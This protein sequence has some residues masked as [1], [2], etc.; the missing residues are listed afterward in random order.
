MNGG[1]DF[2]I[3]ILGLGALAFLAGLGAWIREILNKPD[4]ASPT[5]TRLDPPKPARAYATTTGSTPPEVTT[6]QLTSTFLTD[7]AELPVPH[8]QEESSHQLEE[9]VVDEFKVKAET[10]E[11]NG[12]YTESLHEQVEADELL[13]EAETTGESHAPA[14]EEFELKAE[15]V[16]ADKTYAESLQEQVDADEPPASA[17]APQEP[18]DDLFLT[19][20]GNAIW[21]SPE[22]DKDNSAINR[23]IFRN[24]FNSLIFAFNGFSSHKWPLEISFNRE[25][26]KRYTGTAKYENISVHCTI[27]FQALHGR[28]LEFDGWWQADR[29]DN[30]KY[31]KYRF[32]GIL[33]PRGQIPLPPA[34][35]IVRPLAPRAIPAP[36]SL[37]PRQISIPERRFS[38]GYG[39]FNGNPFIEILENERPWGETHRNAKKHFSFG[40][41]KAKMI[42][43][44]EKQ[45][46]EFVASDGEGTSSSSARVQGGSLLDDTVVIT[47]ED[48]FTI[49][50]TRLPFPHIKLTHKEESIGFGLSKADA[51]LTLWPQID[52]W[53]KMN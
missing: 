16:E 36:E 41:R 20:S 32:S 45:I 7:P 34:G 11:T 43:L 10:V 37:V 13:T 23:A 46:R 52:K 5:D 48:S 38:L 53:G 25:T 22:N 18:A 42:I 30:N 24:N 27:T 26:E 29:R 40:R 3:L 28:N 8:S 2:G 35:P 6:T 14:V 51:L 31:M 15:T 44:A 19:C 39:I 9:Q 1:F 4:D 47:I 33:E 49:G 50:S 17:G 21:T 12:I